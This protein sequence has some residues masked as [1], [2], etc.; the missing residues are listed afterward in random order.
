MQ[1]CR[2]A[3]CALLPEKLY[4]R[5]ARATCS[6][7]PATLD[8][9]VVGSKET[10]CRSRAGAWLFTSS[11]SRSRPRFHGHNKPLSRQKKMKSCGP[12]R[13]TFDRETCF[14]GQAG[15]NISRKRRF[16]SCRKICTVPARSLMLRTAKAKSGARNSDW[17]PS[18]KLPPP[19]CY[20]R[21]GTVRMKIIFFLTWRSRTCRTPFAVAR[22]CKEQTGTF[23]M[24][25][26]SA[27]H[28][29]TTR[30]ANGTGVTI[31]STEP[32]NLMAFV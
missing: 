2:T 3:L 20:G 19:D 12:I 27:G 26:C 25:A 22:G 28:M 23:P 14:G 1:S 9:S 4:F 32:A 17:K 21:W 24:F 30:A 10:Q 31:I 15:R 7:K 16:G 8:V 29:V 18:Q 6:H 13:E 5:D 11:L